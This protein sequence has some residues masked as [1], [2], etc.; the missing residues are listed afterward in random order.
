[1]KTPAS[2]Y[3]LQIRPEFTLDDAARLVPYLSSLGVDWLY[4]SPLLESVGA[5]EHGYDVSDPSRV[6]RERGG[7]EAL[8]R[9]AAAAHGAGMG[10]LVDIVPNHLGVEVPEETPWWWD[11]LREGR[12][13]RY[14]EAFDVDW[15]AGDGK[16]LLP[17]LGSAEDLGLLKVEGERLWY[18]EHSYPLAPGTYADG[19]SAEAVHERQH[20]RLVPWREAD[21]RLN[22]RRF[23]AV[24]TLAGVRVEVPWVFEESHAEVRRWVEAGL[25]DGLRIDHPDGLRDPAGYLERLRELSGGAYTLVEKILEPGEALP[26]DFPCEGTTGYDALGLVD[27][28]LV[29]PAGEEPLTAL[30]TRLRG[31]EA[32]YAEMIHGTK[33]WMAD[34][35]LHAEILRLARIAAAGTVGERSGA[36]GSRDA[37]AESKPLDVLADALAEIAAHFPVYRTY[38]RDMT[39]QRG[40]MTPQHR[41]MTPQQE[42]GGEHDSAVLAE[43]CRAA[44]AQRPDLAAAIEALAP[45]LADPAEELCRRFQQTTGMIMAKAVEDTAFYRYTRLGTL[46]EVGGDPTAFALAPAEFHA[47]LAERERHLA[48]SMTTLTTHDTKRSEDTR[49]RITVLS[50][51]ADEWAETL[52]RLLEAAPLEDG[53]L[54]NLLWQAIL[55]AWPAEEDRLVQYAEKAAREAGVHTLWTDQDEAFEDAVRRLVH[56]AVDPASPAHSIISAFAA[57]VAPFGASN[58]LAAKLLQLAMPGVPDVY[59]GTEFWDRSLCDPDNRREV[60]FTARAEALAA[61]DSGMP[62]LGPLAEEA[63]LLVVSRTLRL[64]RDRPELFAGY[65]PIEADG[66]AAAHLVGFRRGERGAAVLATRLP[67]GLER[68]GGWGTTTVRLARAARDAFTG[69]SFEAGDVLVGEVLGTLPVALLVPEEEAA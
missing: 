7:R 11:L 52:P 57:K 60:D 65:A 9:V 36:E 55:G 56:A 25:V 42:G 17:V 47:E 18:Y 8:E 58:A 44:A 16:V 12:G 19:D 66:P 53:P 24:N 35:L 6:D 26:A 63:K 48:H 22:Y 43:A 62:V 33:R 38:F 32:D 67:A 10:I 68:A 4:L 3:R 29:D 69:R 27:R 21:D 59:Q 1:M 45:R 51:L 39:P 40:D 30:D 23:F 20:Y 64:R 31:E 54:A 14:A 41:D 28:V 5:S 34:G 61:L 13:S 50:E 46:T 49:A 37:E 2:T 15:D